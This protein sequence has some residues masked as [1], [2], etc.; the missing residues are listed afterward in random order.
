MNEFWTYIIDNSND[1]LFKQKIFE[2]IRYDIQK[3]IVA[4]AKMEIQV[5]PK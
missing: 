4:E 2:F 3:K 5:S 1:E